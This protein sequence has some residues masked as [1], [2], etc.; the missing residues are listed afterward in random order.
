MQRI[1]PAATACVVGALLVSACAGET[2]YVSK[3]RM[4]HGGECPDDVGCE[5]PLPEEQR[6]EMPDSSRAATPEAGPID[7]EPARPVEVTC[8]LVGTELASHEVGNYAEDEQL[9]PVVAR[10]EARCAKEKL[11]LEERAC[12]LGARADASTLSYCAPR[13][14]PAFPATIL[15][16]PEC[17]DLA[18]SAR[19]KVTGLRDMT[20]GE[21]GVIEAK[22][23]VLAASCERDRWP[24]SFGECVRA[25]ANPTEPF[26]ACLSVAPRPLRAKLDERLQ[27]ALR[28]AGMP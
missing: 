10:W 5:A 9:A 28:R 15:S 8:R 20:S 12:I 17:A 26:Q 27:A 22:L 23:G 6:Y 4:P 13:M 7:D 21:R 3:F 18:A 19:A 11:S 16:A 1:W 14:F 24:A 2:R 25:G